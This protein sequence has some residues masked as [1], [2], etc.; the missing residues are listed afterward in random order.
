MK[1]GTKRY[2]NKEIL[3]G[4]RHSRNEVLKYIYNQFYPMI[5]SYIINNSGNKEEARDIFQDGI[6]VLYEKTL[7]EDFELTA[8]V[9][10]YL[11]SVC[12]RLWL[13]KLN[14]QKNREF[15]DSNIPEREEEQDVLNEESAER[16][17]LLKQLFNKIG[18]GCRKI[19]IKKYFE[20][21]KDK[22]IAE[23]LHLSGPD[24]VKMQRYRCLKQLRKLYNEMKKNRK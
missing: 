11:Y 15:L 20:K 22:E 3:D 18:E 16:Q 17:H 13:N 24:Y 9:G 7:K 2:N 12:Q 1:E 14:R 19:L 8:N 23:E 10:T 21:R 4:I 6:I 5:Y